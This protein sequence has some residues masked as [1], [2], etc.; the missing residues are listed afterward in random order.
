LESANLF[1]VPLDDERR[2]Y[3]YHHLFGDLLRHYLKQEVGAQGLTSLHRRACAWLAQHDLKTE[4]L[5]HAIAGEDFERAA[6]LIEAIAEATV[7]RG[8]A[9]TVQ[10]WIDAL[11]DSLLGWP[12]RLQRS[13]PFWRRHPTR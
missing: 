13:R 11:P 9:K 6:D 3:R 8:A 7:L 12:I 2:W 10:N 1:I 4:A 5:H